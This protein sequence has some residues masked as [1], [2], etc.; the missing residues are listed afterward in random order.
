MVM[1]LATLVIWL[2]YVVLYMSVVES[3]RPIEAK[4]FAILVLLFFVAE[5]TGSL[6][7]HVEPFWA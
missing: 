6:L 2:L 7:W 5:I 1:F 4:D 3:I